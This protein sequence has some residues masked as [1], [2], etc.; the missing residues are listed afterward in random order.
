M[1]YIPAGGKASASNN[2]TATLGASAT[3]VGTGELNPLPDVMVSCLAD[4]AG[5]LYF[6]F[7]NDNSNWDTFPTN[8]FS[9]DANTHEFHVAV[10]GPRYFR[11]RYVNGSGAQSTFRLYTYFGE[12]RQP[13]SPFN[14]SLGLDSDSIA[15]RPTVAQDEIIRSLRGGV[16]SWSPFGYRESTTAAAGD[17][18]IWS[19]N[20]NVSVVTSSD[21]WT[22]T[23]NNATDGAGGGAT[24]ALTLLFYYLDGN[25]TLQ[26]ATHTL[27]SSGSDTTSFSGL[28]VNR[29]VVTSSGSNLANVND[30]TI[31]DTT[32]G[33]TQ[34]HI[35]AGTSASQQMLFHMPTGHQGILKY[36]QISTHKLSGSN[37]KVTFKL[38]AYN[39]T[40]ATFYMF[41]RWVVD[42]QSDTQFVFD[43]PAG[44]AIS[45]N[46]FIYVTMDTDQNNT[47]AQGSFSLNIYENV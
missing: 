3:Y 22:V 12:F 18:I 6:D 33:G 10:K 31:T 8:G 41:R 2:T 30:I 20:A 11:A 24:G 19:A 7:S 5:T 44:L 47:I 35:P 23:Y 13:N 42:T 38:W 25:N 16:T 32:G 15:V 40:T 37:P 45:A 39:R 26:T 4:V 17:E 34:A 1:A 43:D 46:D 27:G 36:M 29:V 28:G 14:Q 21:T 9:V